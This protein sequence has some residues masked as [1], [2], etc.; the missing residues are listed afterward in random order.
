MRIGTADA[1]AGAVR[2]AERL[3]NQHWTLA[4]LMQNPKWQG[5]GIVVEQKHG[6]D[7]VLIPELAWETEIYRRP[8]RPL[9][10]TLRLAVESVDLA[11]RTARFK[12][13]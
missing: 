7:V 10:S 12:V 9:D 13:L 4:Y 2:T 8:S 5:E 6:R 3:S 1:I 11:N